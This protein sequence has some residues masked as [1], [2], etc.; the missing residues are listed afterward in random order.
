MLGWRDG[1]GSYGLGLRQMTRSWE[2]DGD[3]V[4][5]RQGEREKQGRERFGEG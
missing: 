4:F 2:K 1:K 5:Y 3:V